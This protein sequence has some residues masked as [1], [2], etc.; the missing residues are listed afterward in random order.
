MKFLTLLLALSLT[1]PF[2]AEAAKKKKHKRKPASISKQRGV[3]SHALYN[4]SGK[5]IGTKFIDGGV[6]CYKYEGAMSCIKK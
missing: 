6:T 1:V 3:M 5:K 2:N 4:K